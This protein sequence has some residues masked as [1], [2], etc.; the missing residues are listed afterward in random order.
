[1]AE[2]MKISCCWLYAISKYGYPVP[3]KD[4]PTALGEMANLGFRYVELEGASEGDNLLQ[5]YEKR[6][7]IKSLC[8]DLG[9]QV[10]N[11]CP[12]LPELVSLDEA[13]RQRGYDLFKRAVELA[14]FFQCATIQ[15]DSYTPPLKFIG[16]QPYKEMLDYGIEF[17]VEVDPSFRWEEQ[18]QVL[19]NTIKYCT[20]EA[21]Q[22]DLPLCLEPR[23]GEII[24]NT[25]ALLRL[26]D[27]VNEE[28]FGAV[29]DTA[30]QH[31]QKEILP[32]SVEKLGSKIMYLH[33]ADNDGKVNE[34]LAL[35]EGTVDWEGVFKALK[36][37]HFSGYVAIDVGR[38]PNMDEAMRRSIAFLK[39]LLPK[40]GIAYEI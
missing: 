24:S 2:V 21:R 6:Q 7:E 38:L 22:A 8:E 20:Q 27:H 25:D 35:G 19:V 28:T 10:I 3:V 17:R 13:V 34:H 12:V 36:K 4:I 29:L 32:L 40:L 33:V 31:A 30:H 9:L 11:F 5:L 1:M 23:V 14:N 15:I 16:D 37:H 18:W 39:D 26:M